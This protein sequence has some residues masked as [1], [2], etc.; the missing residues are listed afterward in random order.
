MLLDVMLAVDEGRACTALCP[1]PVLA[2]RGAC[3]R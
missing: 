1:C 3:V 2:A